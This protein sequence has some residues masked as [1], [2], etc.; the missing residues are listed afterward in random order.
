MSLCPC[1][2]RKI[3][4]VKSGCWTR[5]RVCTV[6]LVVIV[7][8]NSLDSNSRV[9]EGVTVGNCRINYLY[10]ADDLIP[11]AS[12]EQDSN[13]HFTVVEMRETRFFSMVEGVC[14]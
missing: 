11:P 13:M 4:T 7:C 14:I 1:Q 5:T 6:T 9:D 10:F 2:R 3:T 8:I 12:S